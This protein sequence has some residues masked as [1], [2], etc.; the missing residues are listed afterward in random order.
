MGNHY[1]LNP[2]TLD[3]LLLMR[4]MH[5]AGHSAPQISV[6]LDGRHSTSS[7]IGRLYRESGRGK[8]ALVDP[9][10]EHNKVYTVNGTGPTKTPPAARLTSPLERLPDGGAPIT[11]PQLAFLS[12]RLAGE[13]V[14]LNARWK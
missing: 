12:H 3:E 9:V 4:R 13:P 8:G 6:A 5:A 11:L 1:K 7:V 10:P 2:W 14:D